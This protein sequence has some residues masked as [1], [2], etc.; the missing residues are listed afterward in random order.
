MPKPPPRSSSAERCRSARRTRRAGAGSVGPRPRSPRRRRSATRCGSGSRPGPAP[1]A[2][3]GL[4]RRGRGA[5]GDGETELLVLVRGGDVLVGVCLDP[6]GDPH[7][8]RLP[9]AQLGGQVAQPGDLGERVDDDPPHTGGQTLAQFGDA[10][11]VAVQADPAEVDPGP[12]T[13]ASSPPVQTSMPSP[14]AH[15][16]RNRGGRGR[17]WPR[18]RRPSRRTPRRTRARARGPPRPARTPACRPGPRSWSR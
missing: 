13:T 4:Q 17:T 3:G 14:P 2:R 7:H 1:A 15:P 5:A 6:G 12:L 11:V 8:H 16:A 9:Y 10:L 18:S